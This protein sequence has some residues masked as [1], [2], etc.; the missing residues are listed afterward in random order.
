MPSLCYES[1]NKINTYLFPISPAKLWSIS[2]SPIPIAMPNGDAMEKIIMEI[3]YCFT[4]KLAW[5]KFSPRENAM[6]ALC[7]MT[8]KKRLINWPRSFWRPI[9][10]PSNTEWKD[11]AIN[12]KSDLEKER[13]CCIN[14]RFWNIHVP[15]KKIV[16]HCSTTDKWKFTP[17]LKIFREIN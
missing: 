12:N 7:A 5:A 13:K 8:A 4:F 3:K 6:T 15:I 11:K 1:R 16:Y 9:A 17:T 2:L 10:R 14:E